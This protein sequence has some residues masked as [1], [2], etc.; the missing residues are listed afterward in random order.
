MR[1]NVVIIYFENINETMSFVQNPIFYLAF[2][3]Q[4]CIE[5]ISVIVIFKQKFTIDEESVKLNIHIYTI[6]S[7]F[8][9]VY[10]T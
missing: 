3:P 1:W 8:C 6:K 7:Y 10:I 4:S 2:M 5:I 9:C